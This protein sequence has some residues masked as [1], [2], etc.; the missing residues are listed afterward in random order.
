M[1]SGPPTR[2]A[3]PYNQRLLEPT[4]TNVVNAATVLQAGGHRFDPGT[5]HGL[6]KPLMHRPRG[7][8]DAPSP[9]FVRFCQ[10]QRSRVDSVA[11][12]RV[13][14]RRSRTSSSS[15]PDQ[16]DSAR[17]PD[18]PCWADPSWCPPLSPR[19]AHRP[20]RPLLPV[21]PSLKRGLA[22]APPGPGAYRAT[23]ELQAPS[24]SWCVLRSWKPQGLAVDPT[25]GT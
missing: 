22:E 23:L 9:R 1:R 5:L 8:G 3:N 11:R 17:S 12:G 24:G 14:Q 21:L 7:L 16:T 4:R 13:A 15:G 18:G 2:S 10:L 6:V 19:G 20:A 25:S